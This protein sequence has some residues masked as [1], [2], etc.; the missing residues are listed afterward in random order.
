MLGYLAQAEECVALL[1][2]SIIAAAGRLYRGE[3]LQQ[4]DVED[5]LALGWSGS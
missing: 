4:R 1:R 2:T 5:C 3:R